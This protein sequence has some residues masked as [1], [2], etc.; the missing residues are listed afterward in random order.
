MGGEVLSGIFLRMVK[1]MRHVRGGVPD[2]VVWNPETKKF[3]V[4]HLGMSVVAQVG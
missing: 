3:K 1:N 4:L 2:L